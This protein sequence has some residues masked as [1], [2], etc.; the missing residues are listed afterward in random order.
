MSAVFFAV[1]LSYC[2]VWMATLFISKPMSACICSR[3]SFSMLLE[4][5]NAI[6]VWASAIKMP[7]QHKYKEFLLPTKCLER[8]L[9]YSYLVSIILNFQFPKTM[10]AIFFV[11]IL[12][13]NSIS[14]HSNSISS[15]FNSISSN[16][17]S[18]SS[19]FNSINSSQ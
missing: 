18:I 6:K 11:L 3:F 8:V 13:F 17:N 9:K 19:H 16:F 14:S 10:F 4:W 1:T 12:D 2:H 7:D 5:A 15:H